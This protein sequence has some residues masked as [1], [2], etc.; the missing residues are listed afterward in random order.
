MNMTVNNVRVTTI[1]N[2]N[3]RENIIENEIIFKKA[4]ATIMN[5]ESSGL[6]V[7]NIVF[8]EFRIS[9]GSYFNT[10]MKIGMNLISLEK[11]KS[12]ITN[13]YTPLLVMVNV[14]VFYHWISS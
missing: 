9:G 10:R 5:Q 12:M 2:F 7:E 1:A 13:Y 6:S 11:A 8:Y 14:V 3:T 4:A